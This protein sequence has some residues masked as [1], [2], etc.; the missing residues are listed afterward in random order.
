VHFYRIKMGH[1]ENAERAEMAESG[2]KS[3]KLIT[4]ACRC[5]KN[6]LIFTCTC[7]L[8]FLRLLYRNYQF[9][10]YLRSNHVA[11]ADRQQTFVPA[12]ALFL[13]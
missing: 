12:S 3:Y 6:I 1:I 4:T 10:L 7:T 13:E 2:G 8:G 5:S 9:Q 11:A